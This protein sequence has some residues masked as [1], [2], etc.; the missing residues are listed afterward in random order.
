[1]NPIPLEKNIP[2]PSRTKYPFATMVV[3]DS[4]TVAPAPGQLIHHLQCSIRRCS[5]LPSRSH[6][7]FLIRQVENKTAVRVWRT[8]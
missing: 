5:K 4:F 3:G 6:M 7:T 1:M 8:K 2:I